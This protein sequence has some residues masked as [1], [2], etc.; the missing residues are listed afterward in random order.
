LQRS[1]VLAMDK[2]LH[3]P[4][5]LLGA[6]LINY[7]SSSL[8]SVSLALFAPAMLG[9]ALGLTLRRGPAMLLVLPLLAA[10]LLMVTALTYQFQSW[11]A[12]LMTNKRRRRSIIA[13]VTVAFILLCQAP[14]LLQF[15]GTRATRQVQEN[16]Q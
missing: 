15:L 11:L 8:L 13:V 16:I 4:V 7:V 6:F 2:F 10:F 1:E 12:S 9:L 5:S 14:Q 3:L